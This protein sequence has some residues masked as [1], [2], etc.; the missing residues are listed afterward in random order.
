MTAIG[1]PGADERGYRRDIDGLRAVSLLLVIGFHSGLGLFAGGYV[2]VDVFFVLSGYLITGLLVKEHQRT[3]RIS[4]TDFYARRIRRLLPM[5]GL[6]LVSTVLAGLWLLPPLSRMSLV[7]DARAAALYI[8]NWR[9]SRQATAYSD[10]EVTDA[11]LLHYWSLSVEEQFYFVWPLLIF[12][13][14]WFVGRRRRE[15]FIPTLSVVLGALIAASLWASLTL[16]AVRGPEA[17]YVTHTRLWELGVGGALALLVPAMGRIRRPF[18][19]GGAVLG[20]GAI[21]AAGTTYGA[22]TPFPGWAALAPVLGAAALIV[23]GA[24]SDTVVSRLLTAAPLPYLGRIS[25]AWYLWHWPLIGGG[26]LLNER[27]GER[28]PAPAVVSA[29]VAA[30]LA[31]AAASHVLVEN[32]VRHGQFL[33]RAPSRSFAMGA[34][35]TFAPVLGAMA[36]LQMGDTGARQVAVSVAHADPSAPPEPDGSAPAAQVDPMTPQQAAKDRTRLERE[37][38]TG[39]VEIP[40]EPDCVYGDPGGRETVALIGDSHAQHWLPAL[41]IA[42]DER[43]W[44]VVSWTMESC[45]VVDAPI[46]HSKLERRYTEC[47]AWRDYVVDRLA[48]EGGVDLVLVARTH[49][50]AKLV[51][52]QAGERL[53]ASAVDPHWREGARSTFAQL[54][55]VADQVAV[56]RDTPW[57]PEDIPTC[58]SVASTDPSRCSFPREG[59]AGL[60][61]ILYEAESAAALPGVGFLDLTDLICS[62]A[63]CDMVTPEGVIKFRDAHHLTQTFSYSLGSELA[64]ALDGLLGSSQ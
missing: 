64:V 31:L 41:H 13:V 9:F 5:S 14:G 4:L 58:L 18:A 52:D 42:G 7:H 27:L 2:G 10:A 50:Y 15:L 53:H 60:D 24:R 47:E 1:L 43:S 6:V 44:R 56:L 55:R 28:W 49:K 19:H 17:Y 34:A 39:I 48:E 32:P 37:S 45:A 20:I 11:L 62:D 36:F 38:C 21:L 51:L 22:A 12:G 30:S 61:E 16:T 8:A 46:W 63:R 35:L 26:L 40:P 25:Y 54:L 3:G 23:T 59:S 33:R 29:A 57:A